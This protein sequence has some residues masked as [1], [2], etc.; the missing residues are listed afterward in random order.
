MSYRIMLLLLCALSTSVQAAGW[1]T[2]LGELMSEVS[3]ADGWSW[4]RTLNGVI[5]ISPDSI[6]AA[7]LEYIAATDSGARIPVRA[8]PNTQAA[9]L[10]AVHSDTVVV[11]LAKDP[12]SRWY[13]VELADGKV[14]YIE[15]SF[16][17]PM[18]R[19]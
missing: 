13:E 19:S 12:F 6:K 16:L 15:K 9:M 18:R 3:I 7:R 2:K 5:I 8:R 17:R 1:G 14:G 4:L 11:L 10:A